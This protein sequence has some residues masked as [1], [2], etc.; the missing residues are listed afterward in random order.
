MQ[1]RK[2]RVDAKRGKKKRGKRKNL[3]GEVGDNSQAPARKK[4]LTKGK[5]MAPFRAAWP[6][7]EAAE[8]RG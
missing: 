4:N 2:T 5:R 1:C 8:R 7:K 6:R 3:E